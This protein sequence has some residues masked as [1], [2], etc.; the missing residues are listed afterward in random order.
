MKLGARICGRLARIPLTG[1]WY[2]A[3]NSR[4]HKSPLR[5][6]QSKRHHSRF[7]PGPIADPQFEVLYLCETLQLGMAEV[8]AEIHLEDGTILTN[9]NHSWLF[10]NVAVRL[11][12]IVDLT[13]QSQQQLLSTNTQELTGDWKGYNKG[14]P[15]S[16]PPGL[17]P[18]QQLGQAVF[19]SPDT[20][21]FLVPSAKL[22]SK[23]NLV[24]FPRKL[25]PGSH[26]RYT[27]PST[28]RTVTIK[29]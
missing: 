14:F 10:V 3:V 7:N 21:G 9:P 16:H 23:R 13:E 27:D 18:S 17:A 24:V 5:T 12:R 1:I 19:D 20:E 22:L 25:L 6:S 8:E 11:Q 4:F 28:N 29:G 2:R 15:W 26:L